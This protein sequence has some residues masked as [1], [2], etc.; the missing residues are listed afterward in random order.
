MTAVSYAPT[1]S[2]LSGRT[3]A[4]AIREDGPLPVA[5]VRT[6]AVQLLELLEAAHLSGV[7]H[8]NI[9]PGTVLLSDDGQ[10]SLLHASGHGITDPSRSGD[11]IS[12]GA[13]LF[14]AS[15]GR[16]GPLRPLIEGLLAPDPAHRWN[17]ARARAALI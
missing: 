5:Q 4:A 6:I 12:L 16:P 15:S 10:A 13:T 14:A 3:L 9:H 7:V 11:L 8:G 2:A 17:I 1:Q